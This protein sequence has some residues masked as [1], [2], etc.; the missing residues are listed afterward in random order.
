M[1]AA[2]G[3]ADVPELL[4]AILLHLALK[5]ILLAQRVSRTFRDGI[6][7]SPTIQ[8]ALFLRPSHDFTVALFGPIRTPIKD[9]TTSCIDWHGGTVSTSR[10]LLRMA[11]EASDDTRHDIEFNPFAI[12]TSRTANVS[13][14]KIHL[15]RSAIGDEACWR[16]MTLSQPP[17]REVIIDHGRAAHW[18]MVRASM[19]SRG[20]TLGDLEQGLESLGD[21]R[22]R[23]RRLFPSLDYGRL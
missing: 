19:P 20:V 8:R 7:S 22:G 18:H 16:D 17:M 3:V 15:P 2:A 11:C 23:L 10:G 13:P 21:A 4:E 5:D 1:S 12:E 9:C 6:N 14:R